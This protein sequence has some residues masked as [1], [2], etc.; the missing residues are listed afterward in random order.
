MVYR[1]RCR[2]CSFTVWSASRDALVG[3]A[4]PHILDHH[5]QRLTKQDFRVRWDCPYCDSSGQHHDQTDGVEEFKRHLF[6]HVESLVESG[7]HVA[8]AIDGTG[9][10]LVRAPPG[11]AG[12]DNARIHFLSPGDIVLF[13]TVA[14]AERL[15]L[16]YEELHEWPA[17]VVVLTTKSGVLDDIP[18]IDFDELS[19]EIV[20]LDGR[21][22]LSG[23]GETMSRVLEEYEATDGKIAV[24]FDI[25]SELVGKFDLQTVFKFLHVLGKRFD[26]ADAL[27]HYH[28]DPRAQSESTIN[29]LEQSFDLSITAH[30][31]RFVSGSRSDAG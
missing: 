22:G 6:G 4:K 21:L 13:V 24:E 16:L 3:A 25:L 18:G 26:R 31:Q 15:R 11:S 9:S 17:Q 14:P 10:I 23:L 27:A 29:V 12:A 5:R 1:F 2:H 7:V 20:R 28:V 19:L 30:D 8:D